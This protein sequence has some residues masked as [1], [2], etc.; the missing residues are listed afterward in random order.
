MEIAFKSLKSDPCVYTY[1]DCGAI[2]MLTLYVDDVLLLGKDVLMLRR[3]KQ[4]LTS[5]FSMTDMRDVS[6]VLRIGVTR[7]RAKGTGTIKQEKYTESLMQRYGMASCD[8][9]HTPGVGKEL[10]LDEPEERIL[11]KEEKQRFQAITGSVM[12]LGQVTRYGILYAVNQLA[13]AMSKPSK[14]H[15]AVAK[16][17]NRY[18]AGMVDF[19]IT[20]K[21]DGFKLT[22]FSDANCGNNS[23]NG[24]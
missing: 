9:T 5:R 8:S 3:I 6:L 21:Q 20:Y 17:L 1:S 16:H 13:R 11:S 10:S 7:D 14:G 22:A 19:A 2:Y 15:M 18:L 4:K 24:K 12:Y 23:D